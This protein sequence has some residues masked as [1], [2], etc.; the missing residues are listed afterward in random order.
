MLDNIVNSILI[1]ILKKEIMLNIYV[2]PKPTQQSYPKIT[3]ILAN[4][5]K[6]WKTLFN[7]NK[8]VIKQTA[9][10]YNPNLT[11]KLKYIFKVERQ[12]HNWFQ[13]YQSTLS[14]D[15]YHLHQF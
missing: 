11:N 6:I 3:S 9:L 7:K 4:E 10:S 8:T 12:P 14:L 15:P 2:Q 1:I 5:L 13:V